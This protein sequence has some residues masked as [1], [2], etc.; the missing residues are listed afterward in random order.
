MDEPR[1]FGDV[2]FS[3][4][5]RE[6]Y[7]KSG[8]SYGEMLPAYR[9][10]WDRAHEGTYRG[11]PWNDVIEVSMRRR[12]KRNS[13]LPWKEARAAIHEGYEQAQIALSGPP[14]TTGP[15]PEDVAFTIDEMGSE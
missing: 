15:A 3:K 5:Y 9:H 1:H 4:H 12:W 2:D 14:G 13:S 6:H 8:R 10:G 7:K 11:H